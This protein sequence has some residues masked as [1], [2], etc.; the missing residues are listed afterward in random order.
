[1]AKV[2]QFEFDS[3]S[4]QHWKEIAA[5]KVDETRS[6]VQVEDTGFGMKLT[7][8]VDKAQVM[9]IDCHR[10]MWGTWIGFNVPNIGAI[11]PDFAGFTVAQEDET[12]S[13]LGAMIAGLTELKRICDFKT[14]APERREIEVPDP[15]PQPETDDDEAEDHG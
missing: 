3:Y 14:T 13:F 1:M 11:P 6:W 15:V 12:V 9:E 2:V 10:D 4:T 8:F 5:G 7:L